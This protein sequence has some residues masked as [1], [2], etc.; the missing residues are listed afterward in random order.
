[1][2]KPNPNNFAH[3]RDYSRAVLLRREQTQRELMSASLIAGLDAIAYAL[4]Y[5]KADR[6]TIAD[7]VSKLA[8]AAHNHWM[9]NQPEHETRPAYDMTLRALARFRS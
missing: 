2:P 9:C 5:A 1:M 8:T 4:T 7:A 6:A 3:P